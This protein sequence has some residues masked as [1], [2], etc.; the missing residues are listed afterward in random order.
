MMKLKDGL[1]SGDVLCDEATY[2]R[3]WNEAD[4]EKL[5]PVYVK[6]RDV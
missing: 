5:P 4:F 2:N 1:L 6:V 3:C